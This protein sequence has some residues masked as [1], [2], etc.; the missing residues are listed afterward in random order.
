MP[1]V[2]TNATQRKEDRGV[3]TM[4]KEQRLLPNQQPSS[5]HRPTTA[6]VSSPL[7]LP[8]APPPPPATTPLLSTPQTYKPRLTSQFTFDLLPPS[9]SDDP[10]ESLL[11]EEGEGEAWKEAL[12]GNV[13][14]EEDDE[15]EETI[16]NQGHER[17]GK[18]T[19]GKSSMMESEWRLGEVQK[20]QEEEGEEEGEEEEEKEGESDETL[21]SYHDPHPFLDPSK[22][23]NRKHLLPSSV[24]SAH[25]SS[26][27]LATTPHITSSRQP[28]RL[29]LEQ[30][31]QQRKQ[32]PLS[33][34]LSTSL[35][36]T[37]STHPNLGSLTS[38]LAE[39]L[40]AQESLALALAKERERADRA[41]SAVA[42][43]TLAAAAATADGQ[44]EEMESLNDG[45]ITRHPSHLQPEEEEG[46]ESRRV[47]D[48]LK[49]I[50]RLNQLVATASGNLKIPGGIGMGSGD[51]RECD[52]DGSINIKENHDLRLPS[53]PPPPPSPLPPS[54]LNA[55]FQP[56]LPSSQPPPIHLDPLISII[57]P[58]SSASL[59]ASTQA[60]KGEYWREIHRRAKEELEAIRS[61]REVLGVV[62]RMFERRYCRGGG[63]GGDEG[64]VG[65]Y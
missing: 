40:R 28:P 25:S 52:V 65:V 5:K 51:V 56:L 24:P 20:V 1:K 46:G 22:T 10:S 9:P 7:P 21:S 57:S 50:E 26:A 58:S 17:G 3:G 38:D 37:P 49:E 14:V 29:P 62:G 4:S 11:A 23:Q 15:T 61:E 13:A 54:T 8:P 55:T 64:G 34:S 2:K 47:K 45:A 42:A 6:V 27:L 53:P 41:E 31:Q 33:N 60:E 12:L 44:G 63:G 30:Q 36:E 43:V 32:Q 39:S 59:T 35:L 48:L 18:V 19:L 16:Q